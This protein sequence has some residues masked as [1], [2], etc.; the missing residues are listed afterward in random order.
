MIGI[1]ISVDP[2][3]E[4]YPGVSSYAYC[5][6]NPI[7][8]IDPDGKEI[9]LVGTIEERQVILDHLQRL[10][11]DRLNMRDDGTVII[12]RIGG[13]NTDKYL[14]RGSELIRELNR[15]GAG[16]K[17]V[18][19]VIS[20]IENAVEPVDRDDFGEPDWTNATNRTGTDAIIQ[21]T[22]NANPPIEVQTLVDPDSEITSL[23]TRPD[24]IGL[25]HEL[26]HAYNI[27]RGIV[28]FRQRTYNFLTDT[29]P[30]MVTEPK[31]EFITVGLPGYDG[32]RF[33]EN[34]IRKEQGLK[35]R[36]AY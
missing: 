9:K 28:D 20:S 5:L 15:K 36:G 2:K 13:E 18:T 10:T 1:F 24:E 16:A 14:R 6:N 12:T 30:D 23:A 7:K 22:I 25:A 21:F 29:G 26:I 33:T 27:N 34:K 4:K 31:E 19:I 8:Y 17:T 32:R 3:L 35:Q 11:N